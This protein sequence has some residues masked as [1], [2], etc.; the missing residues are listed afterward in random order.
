MV[1]FRKQFPNATGEK[2]MKW[3]ANGTFKKS[4]IFTFQF[5]EKATSWGTHFSWRYSVLVALE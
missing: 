3:L 5:E 2:F 1:L 4:L